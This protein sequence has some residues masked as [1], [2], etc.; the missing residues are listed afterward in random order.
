MY[1]IPW[2][3]VSCSSELFVNKNQLCYLY[4]ARLLCVASEFTLLV[5]IYT[6]T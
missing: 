1:I 4:A 3:S 5:G 2:E 6:V